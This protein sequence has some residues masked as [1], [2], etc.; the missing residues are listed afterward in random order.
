MQIL[1][2]DKILP[3]ATEE[4]IMSILK[5]E[6]LKGWELHAAG[7]FRQLYFRTD[8]PGAVIMMEC[9]SVEEARAVLD[10]LPLVKEGLVD[11]DIIPLGAFLPLGMLLGAGGH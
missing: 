6:A 2:L 4:K 8:R 1:A 7:T 11:F 9:A 10:T 5:E 3:G